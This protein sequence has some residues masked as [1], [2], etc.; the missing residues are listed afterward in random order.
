MDFLMGLKW[1]VVLLL[2]TS[3]FFHRRILQWIR[4]REYTRGRQ[5][6][7]GQRSNKRKRIPT[8]GELRW[9]NGCI[10]ESAATQHF[11]VSGVTGSGKSHV[12][13]LLMR[14][15]LR[16]IRPDSDTRVL[17]YDAKGETTAYLQQIGV[18]AP[19]FSLNPFEARGEL[20]MAVSWD[21]ARDIT[22]PTRAMNFSSSLIKEEDSGA[23]KYFSSSA[24]LIVQGVI[25][26][27]I[28]H[29]GTEWTFSDLVYTTLSRERLELVLGRDQEGREILDNFL[30]EDRTGQAVLTSV[31]A[32]MYYFSPVA[33]LWQRTTKRL[34]IRKWLTDSSI[35]LLGANQAASATLDVLNEQII[36]FM[37]EEIDTQ[38]NS[39]T[40]RTW[41]WL[42]EAREAK[43]ILQSG[44]IQ[45]L[46][47]KGRSRGACLVLGFQDI[48][49][50]R[51][52]CGNDKLADEII[53]QCS[54]KALL[55]MESPG[56]AEWASKIVGQ[57]E[58][59][60]VFRS[61][62]T[63]GRGVFSGGHNLSE[64]RVLKDTVLP[65]EF[66]A[67]PATNKHNGLTGYYTSPLLG[68][69]RATTV[70]A[71]IEPVVVS[72]AAE[73]QHAIVYRPESDQWLRDWSA[74]DKQRLSLPMERDL[75]L[76]K[77]ALVEQTKKTRLRLHRGQ[78]MKVSKVVDY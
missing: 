10:P 70:P 62:N 12:Q 17:I 55:R 54:H 29:S 60:E 77:T 48:E 73:N 16:R 74:K 75:V 69:Y 31:I 41:V 53:G 52:A 47:V 43:R 59:I 42:D 58:T 9:G 24:R 32:N 56:S 78:A 19:I 61:E 38:N 40:R 50:F 26:S 18:Q 67:I 51:E 72:E 30:T 7:K 37:A 13:R 4:I 64:Q 8:A 3:L 68:A 14:D 49:G 34:S 45:S 25:L 23:N 76:E 11:L 20:P 22:S 63:S 28:K 39:A 36:T 46:A 6:Q 1:C 35:L 57:Y 21:I 66:Y 71:D 33:A 5:L 15:V 65:S 2:V 27:F 44:A